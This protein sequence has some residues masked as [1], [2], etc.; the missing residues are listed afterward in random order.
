MIMGDKDTDKLF[1]N[2]EI[3]IGEPGGEMKPLKVVEGSVTIESED[4]EPIPPANNSYSMTFETPQLEKPWYDFTRLKPVKDAQ[5]MLDRMQELHCQ[6]RKLLG[7]GQRRERRRIAK[8][9]DTLYA[10]LAAHCTMYGI[11]FKRKEHDHH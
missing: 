2:P 1:G 6:Y 10:K 4:S 7:M 11:T 9:F 8:E 3:L 5:R